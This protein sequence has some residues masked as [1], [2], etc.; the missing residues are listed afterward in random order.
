MT[1]TLA[2]FPPGSR[3]V[4]PGGVKGTVERV[5]TSLKK[6]PIL[7]KLD[8]GATRPYAPAE[9]IRVATPGTMQPFP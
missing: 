5:S 8:T 3:V 4:T 1:T 6:W 2:D 9:L 7:V